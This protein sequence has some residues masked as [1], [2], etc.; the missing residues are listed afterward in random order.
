MIL[1]TPRC[2]CGVSAEFK[3][4]KYHALMRAAQ[5]VGWRFRS[6]FEGKELVVRWTCHECVRKARKDVYD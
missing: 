4:D 2:S 5:E 6:R 3:G 1:L